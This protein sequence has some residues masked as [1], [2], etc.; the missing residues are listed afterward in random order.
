MGKEYHES[1]N[2]L[3]AAEARLQELKTRE[4]ESNNQRSRLLRRQ[5]D[6]SGT[7]IR[8]SGWEGV[9]AQS[10]V[11]VSGMGAVGGRSAAH[12][13]GQTMQMQLERLRQDDAAWAE[14]VRLQQA[15]VLRL[16]ARVEQLQA[17]QASAAPAA[18][19]TSVK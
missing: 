14:K 11:G 4:E 12:A 9:A 16:E 1:A 13:T 8:L 10:A 6:L 17:L 19:D 3:A 2:A 18:R 15:S 7:E 5:R